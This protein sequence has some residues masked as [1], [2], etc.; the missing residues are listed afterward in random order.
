MFIV[1]QP[2]IERD[3]PGTRCQPA[4]TSGESGSLPRVYPAIPLRWRQARRRRVGGMGSS[5]AQWQRYR[6]ASHSNHGRARAT[7]DVPQLRLPLFT[8]L[9]HARKLQL[10]AS[11]KAH[12]AQRL[13]SCPATARIYV[14]PAS[15]SAYTSA[16]PVSLPSPTQLIFHP[17]TPK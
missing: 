2:L 17:V 14:D 15:A 12:A 8:C 1:D 3:Y 4:G 6:P 13:S 10:P 9:S 5:F 11:N 16:R 7:H